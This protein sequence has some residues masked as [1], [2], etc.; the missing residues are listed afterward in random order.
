MRGG[1]ID[2]ALALKDATRHKQPAGSGAWLSSRTKDDLEASMSEKKRGIFTAHTDRSTIV[3]DL[4]GLPEQD[5][6]AAVVPVEKEAKVTSS[7]L[8]QTPTQAYLAHP[9]QPVKDSWELKTQR[10]EEQRRKNRL[11]NTSL[12]SLKDVGGGAQSS[13][14]RL[15]QI[16]SGMP[17]SFTNNHQTFFAKQFP[18]PA[19]RPGQSLSSI[20]A[21]R[22]GRDIPA[23]AA[24]SK[25]SAEPTPP[26]KVISSHRTIH[27]P[28]FIPLCT[29]LDVSSPHPSHHL[30]LRTPC[31]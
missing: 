17:E 26:V 22:T 25:I 11:L 6:P 30:L 5:V 10:A 3:T 29:S 1:S 8:I 20:K 12:G 7:A 24:T 27:L 18:A 19:K 15:N 23:S 14:T 4:G 21:P 16:N 31:R 9:V 28:M 13:M 2:T